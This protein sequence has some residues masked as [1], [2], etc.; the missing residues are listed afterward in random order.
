VPTARRYHWQ[1]LWHQALLRQLRDALRCNRDVYVTAGAA[2]LSGTAGAH[3][4]GR[5]IN[6]LTH[7]AED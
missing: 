3:D 1:R 5:R 6:T 7:L 4:A 2:A